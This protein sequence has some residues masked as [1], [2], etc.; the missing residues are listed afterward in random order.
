LHNLKD[1]QLCST[2]YFTLIQNAVATRKIGLKM[3]GEPNASVGDDSLTP[4][5]ATENSND[6]NDKASAPIRIAL[7]TVME[8]AV[9]TAVCKV[10]DQRDD[11]EL[12]VVV[13]CT[14]PKSRRSNAHLEV[15]Q[16]LWETG[17]YNTDVI[18]SNKRSK[19]AEIMMLYEVDMIMSIGYPWLL[20]ANILTPS[21]PEKYPRS[22]RL[23]AVNIHNSILPRYKGPNSFGW[24]VCNGDSEFGFSS[25][26][27]GAEFDD[28][29]ILHSWTV[30]DDNINDTIDDLF[31]KFGAK[32]PHGVNKT[33]DMMLAGDP[34]RPQ[35]GEESWA[36]KFTDDFRWIEFAESTAL[37]VHN[38]VRAFYGTRDIPK[39]ALATVNGKDICITRTFYRPSDDCAAATP[40]CVTS[41]CFPEDPD[42]VS[43]PSFF[44]K[45][46]DTTLEVLEWGIHNPDAQQK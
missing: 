18:V 20:P 32:F 15:L 29:P 4:S 2:Y 44:V 14:G 12:A 16:S 13:T 10:I 31:P 42:A 38:K 36:P 22:P 30:S 7:F 28:G 11:V 3:E 9:Y 5:G 26:R 25:H 6:D 34:G 17:H 41:G 45:C 27:M 37:E 1:Q 19:Y 40:G 33:I 39:G 43:S 21:N 8:F 24:S 35:V 23:G 46:K